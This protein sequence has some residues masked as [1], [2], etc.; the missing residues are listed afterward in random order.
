MW[1]G[2]Q[3]AKQLILMNAHGQLCWFA[4]LTSPEVRSSGKSWA[5][6]QS[7]C[8]TAPY[9]NTQST[10]KHSDQLWIYSVGNYGGN[11]EQPA[12]W[13]SRYSRTV[14]FGQVGSVIVFNSTGNVQALA[15][16][17]HSPQCVSVFHPSVH[18]YVYSQH[19]EAMQLLTK[20]HREG[21]KT[22][23][24][25][26]S[27]EKQKILWSLL[28]CEQAKGSPSLVTLTWSD[29]R[30]CML[31]KPVNGWQNLLAPPYSIGSILSLPLQKS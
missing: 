18:V 31:A 24:S 6:S 23:P 8:K 7:G 21:W 3:D 17:Q 5:D 28:K 14:I 22:S 9:N 26:C 20:I 27:I 10:Y 11:S 30:L 19:S 29:R 15:S 2:Q 12:L 16:G 25:Q 13:T 4:L 1:R